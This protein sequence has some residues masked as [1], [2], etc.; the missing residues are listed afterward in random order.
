MLPRLNETFQPFCSTS[1]PCSISIFVR[2]LSS[3]FLGV[4]V[5]MILLHLAQSTV[6]PSSVSVALES[7]TAPLLHGV[8][9]SHIAHRNYLPLV[10]QPY[11]IGFIMLCSS[12]PSMFTITK[13]LSLT[14]IIFLLSNLTLLLDLSCHPF[15]FH[16]LSLSP[17]FSH[18]L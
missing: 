3:S 16:L 17:N 7:C 6:N 14:I 1:S 11:S 2:C 5:V 4:E 13:V 8:V 18:S 12:L 15:F 10:F 9:I